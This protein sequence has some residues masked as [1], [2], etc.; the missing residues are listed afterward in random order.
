MPLPPGCPAWEYQTIPGH[1]DVLRTQT[2]AVLSSLRRGTLDGKASARDTRNIHL[3]LFSALVPVGFYYYAGHYRG[4]AYR[5]LQPYEVSVPSDPRVGYPP[6][7]VALAMADLASLVED[8][9]AA[10]DL[11]AQTPNA[12]VSD[13]DKLLYAV[14]FT[15]RA[16]VDLLTIHPYAN[17]NGHAARFCVWAIL[18]Q[19]GYWPR[20]WP[21]EP[22]PPDPPYSEVIKRY[23]D[24]DR[25][26]LE[27]FVLKCIVG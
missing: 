20:R 24:G 11:A 18:G 16:F 21:V 9:F 14:V 25:E 3:A 5:C 1:A 2:A 8:G 13:A 7:E 4:E 26:P 23:R 19:Y 22:R 17:G 6:T 10:L 27:T 15:C 12:Q